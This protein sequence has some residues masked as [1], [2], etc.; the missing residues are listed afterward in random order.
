MNQKAIEIW[1]KWEPELLSD[2]YA[3][4]RIKSAQSKKLTPLK[5]D[6]DDLYAYFQGSHGNYETFLDSCPCGDFRR[7]KRPCKH[8]FRLAMELGLMDGEY[9]SDKAAVP[10][11]RSQIVP[12]NDTIDMVESLS[13]EAQRLLLRIIVKTSTENPRISIEKDNI[14]KELLSSGLLESASAEKR[15]FKFRTKGKLVE[16][17]NKLALFYDPSW[18]KGELELYCTENYADEMS[19]YFTEQISVFVP[20]QY[21]KKK[22]QYYL[23]RKHDY[24]AIYDDD[25]PV[26]IPC[27][28]TD[29]PEDDVTDQLITRGYYQRK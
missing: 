3:K 7:A 21:N 11:A 17:L 23:H 29:L 19:K 9:Q 10:T 1:G 4:K 22:M 18:K 27:L 24:E 26:W 16:I 2:E 13:E 6:K 5:V 15:S 12:L 14:C 8:M 28:E 25:T 20:T